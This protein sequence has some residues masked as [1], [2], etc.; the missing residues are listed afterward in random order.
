MEE[1]FSSLTLVDKGIHDVIFSK[2]GF[3][4]T[5]AVR[6]PNPKYP[7]YKSKELS[8]QRQPL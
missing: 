5:T 3:Y 4:I 8:L 7:F 2:K 1:M 6:T